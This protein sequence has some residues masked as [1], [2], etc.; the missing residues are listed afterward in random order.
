EGEGRAERAAGRKTGE[1]LRIAGRDVRH[2]D[3]GRA[4][5]LAMQRGMTHLFAAPGVEPFQGG[6]DDEGLVDGVDAEMPEGGLQRLGRRR[7][8]SLDD[9]PELDLTG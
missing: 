8:P 3:V 1:P 7:L 4:A 9:H 6:P 2:H 5:D